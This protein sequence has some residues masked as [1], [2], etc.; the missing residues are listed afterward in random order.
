VTGDDTGGGDRTEADG[1]GRGGSGA[2]PATL[3]VDVGGTGIKAS[4]LDAAGEMEGSRVRVPTTYPMPPERL[5]EVVRGLVASLPSFER[6][7]VGFPGV[8]R[9]GRVLTAPHFVTT[10]GPGTKVDKVLVQAWSGFDLAGAVEHALGRPT[11]VANDAD[12]QGAAVVRGDG[13]EFVVT[14]GTGVG[15]ALFWQGRLA[16]H[17]ELAH[18]P[19]ADGETYN[20][21]LGEAARRRIGT[22]RWRRRVLGAID[23]LYA[24]VH[25]DRLYI[26]GGN[27]TRL[28]GHVPDG[29]VLVDN[30]AGMLG[31]IK[32]WEGDVF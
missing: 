15:T 25:Y 28:A 7:S 5:V 21:R 16:P 6:V 4:V 20:E 9:G 30:D 19:L 18:H 13:L 22:K 17:L 1:A 32:L 14:L 12:V 11:R 3:A 23:V 31:G 29:V 8:V 27:A 10:H 24:L 26:G 2:V